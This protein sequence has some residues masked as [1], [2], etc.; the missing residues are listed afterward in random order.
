MCT[1]EDV[2][3]VLVDADKAIRIRGRALDKD[4]EPQEP[5]RS[6]GDQR[7]D[8]APGCARASSRSA[9]GAE[10]VAL[11]REVNAK[12]RGEAAGAAQRD[13]ILT[14]GRNRDASRFLHNGQQARRGEDQDDMPG[15]QKTVERP[16]NPWRGDRPGKP[17]GS[18]PSYDHGRLATPRDR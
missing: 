4:D 3:E 18:S 11:C 1:H 2:L 13:R 15:R 6:N 16:P 7:V 9:A 17:P 14:D 10:T 12:E 8:D 5:L